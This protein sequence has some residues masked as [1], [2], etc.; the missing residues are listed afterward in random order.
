M[1]GKHRS[2]ALR[3]AGAWVGAI[4]LCMSTAYA[5]DAAQVDAGVDT[6]ADTRV[7]VQY[8][9]PEHFTEFRHAGS[10]VNRRERGWLDT[11]ARHIQQRAGAA[12]PDGQHLSIVVT[13]VDRAGDYEPWHGG[14][15]ADVRIVRDIYPPSIDLNFTLLAADG[16]ILRTGQSRLHDP[17]FMMRINPYVDDPLRYEKSLVDGW[18]SSSFAADK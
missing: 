6:R 12:L 8:V 13:D 3:R 7:D 18:V 14:Q 17:A 15:S 10:G 16:T 1:R 11:L 2:A 5:G 9:D 4:V